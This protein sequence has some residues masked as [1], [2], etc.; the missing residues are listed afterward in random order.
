MI[1][2]ISLGP[3]AWYFE[4]GLSTTYPQCDKCHFP[5]CRWERVVKTCS[6]LRFCQSYPQFPQAQNQ[7]DFKLWVSIADESQKRL[8]GRPG[9]SQGTLDPSNKANLP[10]LA[11]PVDN[12]KRLANYPKQSPSDHHPRPTSCNNKQ[13]G[14]P[15]RTNK[16]R[17]RCW[18]VTLLVHAP[19]VLSYAP[20]RCRT[21]RT[22]C[23]RLH[24]AGYL[25]Q[26]A[27]SSTRQDRAPASC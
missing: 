13:L 23:G 7:S 15:I 14:R 4:R 20:S 9:A 16:K 21:V 8:E 2:P 25:H 19:T 24:H 5:F 18:S 11:D 26:Q 1:C 17:H 12:P 6:D 22:R 3:F 27:A 10:T